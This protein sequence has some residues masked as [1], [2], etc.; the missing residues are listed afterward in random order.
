MNYYILFRYLHLVSIFIV[1]G[2]VFAQQF[3]VK[4]A[5]DKQLLKRILLT[6]AIYGIASVLTV[7][8]GMI[9]WFVVGKPPEFYSNSNTF[10]IKMSLF[11]IVGILSLYP[12][13]FYFKSKKAKTALIHIPQKLIMVLRIEAA[14]LLII[15]FFA[16]LMAFGVTF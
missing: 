7:T 5:V 1:V 8:F 11:I 12:S 2:S 3:L 16:E 6:D 14:L 10:W 13:L 15:P 9:L 4:T